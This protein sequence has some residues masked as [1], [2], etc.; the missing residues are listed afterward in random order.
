VN[1]LLT[2]LARRLSFPL[3]AGTIELGAPWALVLVVLPVAFALLLPP[4]R[5]RQPALR[6]PFFQKVA[7]SLG[8]APEKGAVI[9]GKL[10]FQWLLAPLV[11]LLLVLSAARPELVE[12]PIRKTQSKRDL[13]LA[14]DISGSMNTPDFTDPQGR[15]IQRLDAVKLVL[16]DFIARREGDRLGLLVFGDAPHVQAPFTLDHALCLELLDEVAVGMAGQRTMLGD[17]VGLSIKLFDDSKAKQKVVVLLT[18]GNDTG[19]RVPPQKAAEIAKQHG[20]TIHT[21]G[22][23]D[24]ATKGGE[25]VDTGTLEAIAKTTGGAHFL[26]LDRKDLAGIYER[27]DAIEKR[28]I[29]TA[30]YRPRRP[31]FFWPLGAAALLLLAF[32]ATMT[33]LTVLR[34]AK[35]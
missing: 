21:V 9:P 34:E 23:G 4:H 30:S 8:R 16:K 17:A 12:P 25:L 22:I 35:A 6:V 11:F 7:G 24:P 28:E 10:V 33:T 3:G 2:A 29:E 19:S 26:A 14:V 32:Y 18:D 31:L 20:I 27:I 15:K 5:E 13:L 1:E